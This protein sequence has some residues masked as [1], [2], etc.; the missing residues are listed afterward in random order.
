MKSQRINDSRWIREILIVTNAGDKVESGESG[1][2]LLVMWSPPPPLEQ[3]TSMT[4]SQNDEI[5]EREF[6][7]TFDAVMRTDEHFLL[8]HSKFLALKN[9]VDIQVVFLGDSLTRRWEDH[10]DLWNRYF[11]EYGAANLGVGGDC[12]ENIKWRI[13]NGEID[14]IDPKVIIIL[15]GTNNLDKN[16]N[17]SILIG[18]Q[19]I[20]SIVQEKLKNTKIVLLGLLPRNLDGTGINY[21]QRIRAINKQLACFYANTNV[22]FKD[23]GIELINKHGTV[24]ATIMPDGLHLNRDGYE[25]FGPKIKN[26]IDKIW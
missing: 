14:E 15:A 16:N 9:E 22:I 17:E 19:E 4:A 24:D 6:S 5:T 11:S 2:T 13:S 26:I 10:I 20:V 21:P 12:L 7:M 3:I 1:S 23:I 8:K 18:I 25:I